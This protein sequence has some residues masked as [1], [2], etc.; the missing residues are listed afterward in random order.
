MSKYVLSLIVLV[1]FI[2]CQSDSNE[3]LDQELRDQI[4]S[5]SKTGQ[6]DYFIFPDSDD[7]AHLPNQ[8]PANPITEEKVR[9]GNFLFFETGLAQIPEDE[10]CYE[11]YSCSSCHLPD[12]GFLPG[13]IQGIADGAWGYGDHGEYRVVVSDYKDDLIPDAQGTRPMSPLNSGYSTVTLWSGA[14]GAV[15]PNVGTE[16]A[17]TGLSEVNHT[18]YMGLEAQNI[19]AFELHRLEINDKVL[20]EY[21]YRELYDEAFPDFPEEDRYS[22]VTSSFAIGAFLR[23]FMA[24]QAPFQ[25]W[26]KGD[27]QAMTDNQKE[28]AMLFFG[29]ANCTN[30]HKEPALNAMSFHALGTKDMYEQGGVNTGPD[31]VRNLGRG[32]FTGKADDMRKFKVPQLYNLKDYATYFHGSSKESIRDVVEFKLKASSENP[33]VTDDMLSPLFQPVDLTEDEIESLVDF[34]SNA[35]YDGNYGRYVPESIPSGNCFPNNDAFA[36]IDLDCQ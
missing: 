31:D 13:R 32:M 36:K 12:A 23:S 2:S 19:E 28:G 21:G 3:S 8:D 1:L 11:T 16:D 9:L 18:G 20:D 17:W 15:G 5:K 29:K 35:L 4:I 25:Q 22:P 27:S 7:Y 34:L 14:F 33:S 10:V 26:L 24:N 30:C 6:L